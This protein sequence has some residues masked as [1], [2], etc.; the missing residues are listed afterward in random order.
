MTRALGILVGLLGAL[1]FLPALSGGFLHYDDAP[2]LLMHDAWRGLSASHLRWML[3]ATVMGPWQPLTWL[4][5]AVEHALWGLSP[6]AFH[7]T[8]LALHAAGAALLAVLLARLLAKA[9]PERPETRRAL[10]AAGGALL[11]AVHPLRV[12]S[13]AWIT[14][15]RDVLCALFYVASALFYVDGRRR[16][17]WLAFVAACLSKG[18]AITLPL[19]FLVLDLYPLKRT[20]SLALLTEKLPY[21]FASFVVGLVGVLAQ[22]SDAHLSDASLPLRLALSLRSLSFYLEKTIWPAGLSPFYPVPRGFSL[23]HASVLASSACVAALAW[24]AW[25]VRK[26]W[27]AVPAALALYAVALLP[28]LGLVR[29]GEQL[30]ADRYS[31]L[32]MLPL[33]GLAAAALL[34]APAAALPLALVLGSLSRAQAKLWRSDLEL[35]SAAE[36]RAPSRPALVNLAAALRDAGRPDEA[37][38]RDAALMRAAPELAAPRV[39]LSA[40]LL[41]KGKPADALAVLEPVG[42]RSPYAALACLNRGLALRGLR[43]EADAEKQLAKAV[44][45]NPGL[46]AAWFQRGMALASLGRLKEALASFEEA[47]KRG[48]PAAARNAAAVRAALKPTAGAR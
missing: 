3:G 40:Y 37:A 30:V 20:P 10:A 44:E 32:A 42:P 41:G 16:S 36:T 11:W 22:G 43:R 8:N 47:A 33:A 35:W 29:F 38:E 39:N 28:M 7:L 25:S 27:P 21:F 12:E 9:A 23:S 13:V 1:P 45:L 19:S 34:R 46:T 14:E 17:S 5:W 6:F 24:S 4:S 15:R 31:H 48:E 26:R 2:N 18:S